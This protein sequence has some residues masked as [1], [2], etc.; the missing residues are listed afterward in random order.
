MPY[1]SKCNRVT[2]ALSQ[3]G[4]DFCSVCASRYVSVVPKDISLPDKPDADLIRIF[5]VGHGT[6]DA[7]DGTFGVPRNVKIRFRS[8]HGD[9]TVSGN[10]KRIIECRTWRK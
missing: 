4:T 2:A 7:S 8:K 1:C 10:E 5:C 6:Y 3:G 9:A